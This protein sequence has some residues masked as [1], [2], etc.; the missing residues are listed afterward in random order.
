MSKEQSNYITRLP[1][2]VT[3]SM[4]WNTAETVSEPAFMI[5]SSDL[6][7]PNTLYFNS[8]FRLMI[9]GSS[10]NVKGAFPVLVYITFS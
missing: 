6:F 5:E 8:N 2:L 1:D 3:D 4:G 7:F 10:C 9:A